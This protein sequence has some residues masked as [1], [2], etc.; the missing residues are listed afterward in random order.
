VP[1]L[2]ITPAVTQQNFATAITSMQANIPMTLA[3]FANQQGLTI[4]EA[5]LSQAT[6]SVQQF[7]TELAASTA[8]L[9]KTE[10]LVMASI[11]QHENNTPKAPVAPILPTQNAN[12]APKPSKAPTPFR[13]FD[14]T[15]LKFLHKFYQILEQFLEEKAEQI[16]KTHG[17]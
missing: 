6:Q 1:S 2:L 11:E 10:K 8:N 13:A 12:N 9:E 5:E 3:N 14:I 4:S 15:Q 17:K 7:Q 16:E